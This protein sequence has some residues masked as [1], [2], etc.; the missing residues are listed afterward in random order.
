MVPVSCAAWLLWQEHVYG[1][2]LPAPVIVNTPAL[3]SPT[4]HATPNTAA[5]VEVMGMAAHGAVARSAEP[6]K[7]RGSFASML[8]TSTALLA[9]AE[10]Q[11]IY[12]VGDSLPGG[13]VL[14][15]IECGR[16][17]LWRKGCEEFLSLGQA[18]T[19]LARGQGAGTLCSCKYHTFT[20]S[21]T[22]NKSFGLLSARRLATGVMLS[23]ALATV[24]HAD[25]QRWRLAMKDAE[26]RD[27][28]QEMSSILG[29][30]VVLDPRVK[31]KITVI[32]DKKLDRAG[33]RRLF[34]SVLDAHNFTASTR[35]TVSSLPRQPIR[36][37]RP[38][39]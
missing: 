35:A 7:L 34:Y 37:P 13:S 39:R 27:V 29:A 14:R 18:T 17:V 12:R 20:E 21:Q 19:K 38:A 5:V 28:V 10:G 1:Q 4:Q 36:V 23:L 2:S 16:V 26:L 11:R 32:S 9:C 30:T 33:V 31:G 25:E 6:L 15:R 24:A 8:G 22:M 3:V